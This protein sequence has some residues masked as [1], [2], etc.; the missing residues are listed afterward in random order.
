MT[1]PT[2]HR[3]AERKLVALVQDGQWEIDSEG[4]IWRLCI[5][6]GLKAGG[7][8]LVPVPRRRCEKEIPG[9]YSMVRAMT[10]GIRVVGAAHRLVWQWLHGDIPDGLVVNHIN[11]IKHDNR[12]SNLEVVTYSENLKHAHRTGLVDQ[13][14]SRN[15]YAKLTD[16]Q[17][18]EIRARRANGEELI[19]IA[20]D[21]GI[22]IGH[23]S[24]IAL[25]KTR[26]AGG[27]I[28]LPYLDGRQHVEM[29]EVPRG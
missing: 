24:A 12:P 18:A 9:G 17:V 26:K 15:P 25:G 1:I 19:P 6:T 5:R 21:F 16:A 23:V 14:G 28:G 13:R 29:P 10:D 27:V 4:R 3:Q 20:A 2:N 8:H 7:S 11:G 22:S